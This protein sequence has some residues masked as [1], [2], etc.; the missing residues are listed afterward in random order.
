[1]ASW[2]I[3]EVVNCLVRGEMA[4]QWSIRYPVYLFLQVVL[5]EGLM[6]NIGLGPSLGNTNLAYAGNMSG[7]VDSDR[8]GSVVCLK[9]SDTLPS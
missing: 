2:A 4:D 8:E 6:G 5:F 3:F 9:Q 1:M 7:E